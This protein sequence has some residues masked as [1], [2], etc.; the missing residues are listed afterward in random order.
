MRRL[1]ETVETAST[2]AVWDLISNIMNITLNKKTIIG[3][4]SLTLSI[5]WSCSTQI[6]TKELFTE[7]YD[8]KSEIYI[9]AEQTLDPKTITIVD[10]AIV[11]GNSKGTPLIE[12]YDITSQEKISEFLTTGNGPDE[13]LMIGNFQHIK[14]N[15]ELLVADLFKGKLL[16]YDVKDILHNNDPKPST[17]YKLEENSALKFDKLFRGANYLVAESRDPQ[18]RILLLGENGEEKGYYLAY[19]DKEKVDKN[20]NDLNNANLYAGNITISPALDKIAMATY[21]AG[22]IDV[23]KLEKD[24]IVPIWNYLEFY[25]Q[26]IEIIPMGETT[27]AARTKKSRSGFTCISSSDKY[28]YAL[29]SG[30]LYEDPT[31]TFGEVVY[32]AS[33]D[34]EDTYKFNLDKSINRLAVDAEDKHL[35]GI[36]PEMDII[37]IPIPKR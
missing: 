18:G 35:Y 9:S 12:V 29:Y 30:K 17:L 26:G 13:V 8:A 22:M 28:I 32:V 24:R 33:W 16:K 7:T 6:E 27:A 5:F 4:S 1:L 31:Y 10:N 20:L 21:C 23:C 2:Q 3:L 25:P 19:P 36:T 14:S 15:D 11:L 37:K 34:G